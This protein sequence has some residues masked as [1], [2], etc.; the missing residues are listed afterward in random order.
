MGKARQG[1]QLVLANLSLRTCRCELVVANL[2]SGRKFELQCAEVVRPWP[3][4]GRRIINGSG[5]RQAITNDITKKLFLK[6][7][8][9][10]W[11]CTVTYAIASAFLPAMAVS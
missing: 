7:T 10:A 3:G 5:L 9:L 1:V 4:L 2:S 6:L 8:A 11:L